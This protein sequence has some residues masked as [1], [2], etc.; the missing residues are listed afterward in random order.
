MRG[1]VVLLG[2]LALSDLATWLPTSV[3][4]AVTAHLVGARAGQN[5]VIYEPDT[6]FL[7]DD[8]IRLSADVYRPATAGP[9]PTLLVR[10]PL[11]RTR[12]HLAFADLLGHFW[13]ERGYNVAIQG[14]RGRF[15]S[16]GT[17][18]PFIHER[19]DGIATLRWLHA[20]PWFDGRLGTFGGSVFG[21][22]QWA[23]ADQTAPGPGALIIQI[24]STDNYRM[25]Y[26]GGAFSLQSALYWALTDRGSEDVFPAQAEL[27]PGYAELPVVHASRK[28]GR[29]SAVFET[30]ASHPTKDAYWRA[31]DGESRARTL[32]APALLMAGW[33]DPY[34]PSQL[35][36][37]EQIQREAAPN[38]AEGSRL[39]IGPWTHAREVELPGGF[40]PGDYR[41]ASLA[42]SLPFFDAL[43]H[44]AGVPAGVPTAKVKLFVMGENVWRDEPAWPLSRAK[45]VAFYLGSAGHANSA[46]GDG[47]LS[48][49]SPVADQ[50]Q[51]AFTYDPLNPVPSLGGAM[52][53][54]AGTNGVA[55]QGAVETRP[56][57][58]VYST[59]PLDAPLEVTGPVS[60]ILHVATTARATDFTAK[61]VDVWP[62]GRA[63]NLSDGILRQTYNREQA[64][65]IRIA[66]WPTC[67]VF[68]Q[69]HRI[70]LEVS[71]SNYPRF[72][73]HPNTLE[74]PELAT[75][76]QIARQTIFH[77]LAHG[78]RLLL[79]LIPRPDLASHSRN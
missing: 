35:A 57:V 32:A 44:P 20:Q 54:L 67:N 14:L 79:P 11:S 8:G 21:Y 61:L 16:A 4:T 72:D 22:T 25:F 3:T 19:D 9:A 55:L 24:A 76:T 23:I 62:D 78:S 56:D 6:G 70:R 69:G 52:L 18:T 2:A 27:L 47:L 66:L 46:S 26:P 5:R 49:I 60:L 42:P 71:S 43:L 33:Y 77:D 63:F 30:W 28:A 10:L 31:V 50:P 64:T 1:T 53:A 17:Y 40:K 68:G 12:T 37:Y 41:F 65:S 38:V 73:R 58:L 59:P 45:E 75:E 7:A 48:T 15:R 29:P 39:I 36:D 13:G 51:D 74:P 34:L